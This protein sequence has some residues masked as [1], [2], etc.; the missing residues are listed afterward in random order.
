MNALLGLYRAGAVMAGPLAPLWLRTRLRRGKEDAARLGER[1][2]VAGLPRPPGSLVWLHGASVGESLSL[3]PLVRRLSGSPVLVTTGTLSSANLMAERLPPGALHQFAPLDLP[4]AVDRFLD[5]WRPALA[6]VAESELWPN[7][8]AAIRRGRIPLGL[9][10]GRLSPRS[11]ARWRRAPGAIRAVLGSFDM[12][13]AQSADDATRLLSLGARHVEVTGNLKFDA[14][15]PAADPAALDRLREAVG[16]R[17]LWL[18]ASTS[19]DEDALLIDV[20]RTL[21]GQRPDLL[22]IVVPRHVDRGGALA[23]AA[24]AAGLRVARR[25]LGQPPDPA[26]QLYVADTMGELG[27]FYRLARAVFVGKSLAGEGGGQNPLEPAA[28]GCAVLHGPR[29]GNFVDIYRDLDRLGGA[30]EVVDGLALASALRILLDDGPR[31]D[32]MG[33]AASDAARAGR[34]ATN[35]T[36]AALRPLLVRAGVPVPP[37]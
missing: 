30:M 25:A 10:N 36:L 22:A 19:P 11:H 21:Q 33:R 23:D 13:L 4:G 27:S 31:R 37:A 6:L 5:H 3:L 18:A 7:T 35:R 15:A 2:G 9:V 17:P 12:V 32:A 26:T 34:G 24:A 14:G 29:V 16:T 1:L 28:L 8:V 20:Q